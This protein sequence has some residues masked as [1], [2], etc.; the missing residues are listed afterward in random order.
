MVR[1]AT[2]LVLF[3]FMIVLFAVPGSADPEQLLD[4][5]Q[6]ELAQTEGPKVT[7][8]L[9]VRNLAGTRKKRSSAPIAEYGGYYV[10]NFAM[11]KKPK[12]LIRRSGNVRLT[13]TAPST[14]GVELLI[15]QSGTKV[16]ISSNLGPFKGRVKK[17]NLKARGKSGGQTRSLK[18]R[19]KNGQTQLTLK[20]K[21]KVDQG[22]YCIY[23][24]KSTFTPVL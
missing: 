3:V 21:S 18:G 13:C 1:S 22:L 9:L 5:I 8:P 7:A 14:M 6:F 20:I 16:S 12:P 4:P 17:S 15:Q 10:A 19:Q 24:Y 11:V 23:K 2:S